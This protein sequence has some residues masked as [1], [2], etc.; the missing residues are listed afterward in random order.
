MSLEAYQD[1]LKGKNK[2]RR[3]ASISVPKATHA[4][5]QELSKKLHTST[6]DIYIRGALAFCSAAEMVEELEK[7]KGKKDKELL[8]KVVALFYKG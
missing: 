1:E 2:G 5:V 7:G 4:K 3:I 8:D 6:S